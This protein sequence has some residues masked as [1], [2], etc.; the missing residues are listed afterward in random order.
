MGPSNANKF[1]GKDCDT[2]DKTNQVGNKRKSYDNVIN[3]EEEIQCKRLAILDIEYKVKE[4]ELLI[5]EIEPEKIK[6][7]LRSCRIMGSNIDVFL[8]NTQDS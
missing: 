4:K 3:W 2:S 7:E 5:R 8:E 1:I 6:I